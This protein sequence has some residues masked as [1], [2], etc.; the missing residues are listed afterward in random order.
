MK[1]F[2]ITNVRAFLER[3]LKCQGSVRIV[4]RDGSERDLKRIARDMLASGMA[5]RIECIREI[6]LITERASDKG[7][8]LNYAVQMQDRR[9]G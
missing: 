5:D 3:V 4:E 1:F 9:V 7:L 8:L 2:H 6:D